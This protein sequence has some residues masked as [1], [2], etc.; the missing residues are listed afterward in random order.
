[1]AKGKRKVVW[2]NLKTERELLEYAEA[3]ENFS[4]YVKCL[5]RNDL[6]FRRTGIEPKLLDYI[7]NIV[8]AKVISLSGGNNVLFSNQASLTEEAVLFDN[9]SSYF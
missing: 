3:Q 6:E 1:M 4:N 9:L 8:Q 5:I 2:F 7:E